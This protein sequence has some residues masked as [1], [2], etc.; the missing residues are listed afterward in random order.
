M[1]YALLVITFDRFN[2]IIFDALDADN[3]TMFEVLNL[4]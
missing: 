3:V 4:G 1:T 2:L